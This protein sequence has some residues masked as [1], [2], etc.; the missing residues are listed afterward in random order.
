MSSAS[1]STAPNKEISCAAARKPSPSTGL[2]SLS[3]DLLIR[4]IDNVLSAIINQNLGCKIIDSGTELRDL[5]QPVASD[6]SNIFD[7]ISEGAKM[8]SDQKFLKSQLST[9]AHSVAV[10]VLKGLGSV[11]WVAVGLLAIAKV[12][13]R[14]DNISANDR[15]C[16][17]L[18]KD[19][20]KLGNT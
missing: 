17:D 8:F 11:H 14:F 18:L 3:L 1:T 20:R 2:S 9:E 12:L 6:F 7:G 4:Y 10:D 16:I 19:M 15:E 13:E 5:V